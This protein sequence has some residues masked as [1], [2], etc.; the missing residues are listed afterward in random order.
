MEVARIRELALQLVEPDNPDTVSF[1]VVKSSRVDNPVPRSGMGIQ[2]SQDGSGQL[3][4]V[5]SPLFQHIN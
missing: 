3:D 1:R 5:M 4:G 2:H